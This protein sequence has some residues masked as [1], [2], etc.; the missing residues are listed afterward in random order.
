[1][2]SFISALKRFS[3]WSFGLILT[4]SGRRETLDLSPAEDKITFEVRKTN[5]NDESND[6]ANNGSN[7]WSHAAY[8]HP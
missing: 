5:S 1:M 7:H 3:S 2:I 6:D 8:D 4:R